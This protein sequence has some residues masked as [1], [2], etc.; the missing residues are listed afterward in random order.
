MSS[1]SS[2]TDNTCSCTFEDSSFLSNSCGASF[3]TFMTLV[4]F[5]L[6]KQCDITDP[7]RREKADDEKPL[8]HQYDFIVVGAGVAG[9]VVSSRLSENAG[10]NVLQIEAGP[11]EPSL[12]SVPAFATKAVGTNLDWKYTTEPGTLAC[13]STGGRCNW[14]RGKMVSGTSGMQGMMYTRP[15]PAILDEWGKDNPGWCYDDTLPYFIKSENNGNPELV[16]PG[17]HGFS[18]PM[19]VQQF[20]SRPALADVVVQAGEQ[21]GYR[22]GDLNGRNQTG[23]AVAQMMVSEGLRLSTS[24]AYVRPFVTKV[25]IDPVTK[26]AK[27]V[28]YIDL[29]GETHEVYASKEV[30]LSAGAVNSP[31]LLL[32]S[33]V[34]PKKDLEDV[35]IDVI[36]DLPGVGQNLVNHVA[37]S[38]GF[39]MDDPETTTLTLDQLEQFINNRTGTLAST[40]L[41]QTTIFMKSKYVTDDVPDLQVFFNGYGAG[42]SRTGNDGECTRTGK[43]GNCG[44]RNI[45]ARPTNV[46]P[47]SKGY[48]KLNSSNPLDHPLIYPNYLESI[49]DVDV[50]VDGIKLCIKL[51]FTPAMQKYNFTLD[52]TPVPGCET[53]TFGSD[54]YFSCVVRTRT[55]AENHQAGSC[56]MGPVTDPMAVVDHQLKVHGV[57]NIRV[58]DTSFFPVNPNCNP[59]SVIIMAAEKAA[60]LIK[61]AWEGEA[62]GRTIQELK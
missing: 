25:L 35:G 57:S 52:T 44:R 39:F 18:G 11:P 55:G 60:D 41:T 15:H 8:Y 54:E 36:V 47:L 1:A 43:L 12:T 58:V 37:G 22:N 20:P 6:R 61:E 2:I 27:G 10:W 14:P 9:P 17:Y 50:L 59:T 4:E 19:I 7:C 5:I 13:L 53:Y 28:E 42:C 40:G 46:R 45:V 49:R 38:I 62:L 26:K 34:G 23:A 24:K 56:K 33:G 51:A 29:N 48:L 32:L 21:L 31:Q 3:I 16:D 30:I